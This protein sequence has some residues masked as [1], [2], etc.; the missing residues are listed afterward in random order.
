MVSVTR[1]GQVY[2]GANPVNLAEV[3][4]L[5]EQERRRAPARKVYLQGDSF[6]RF[7]A[8]RRVMQAIRGGANVDEVL[9]RT[10]EVK[11]ESK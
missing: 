5:V 11:P 6:S 2:F 8:V 4:R 9:L 10:D 1:Q 7:G 3:P